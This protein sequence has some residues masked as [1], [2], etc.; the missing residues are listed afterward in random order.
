MNYGMIATGNH[1]DF[2]TLR[3]ATARHLMKL[4]C[5]NRRFI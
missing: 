1:W 5:E 3:F 4:S 2:I